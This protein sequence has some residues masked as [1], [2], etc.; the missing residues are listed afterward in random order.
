MVHQEV[1]NTHKEESQNVRIMKDG[2]PRSLWT[3]V[4]CGQFLGTC[5]RWLWHTCSSIAVDRD[6]C[7]QSQGTSLVQHCN[8]RIR[9]EKGCRLPEE[10]KTFRDQSRTDN[11][12]KFPQQSSCIPLHI[13]IFDVLYWIMCW[14]FENG[15]HFL[16]KKAIRCFMCLFN[17][18]LIHTTRFCFQSP[19]IVCLNAYLEFILGQ[20]QNPWDSYCSPIY[21][22][23]NSLNY[24]VLEISI[25]C[26]TI[27]MQTFCF[28]NVIDHFQ[29]LEFVLCIL[30]LCPYSETIYQNTIFRYS[31]MF[32][33]RNIH[34]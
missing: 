11:V 20:I 15:I 1:G 21:Q 8:H 13:F 19:W 5:K 14:P 18:F 34:F 25:T 6:L 10:R 7:L 33:L 3:L 28:G 17:T 23:S 2:S 27:L 30:V 9:A 32:F 4:N 22:L 29:T 31:A 12:S 24:N 26:V 16:N